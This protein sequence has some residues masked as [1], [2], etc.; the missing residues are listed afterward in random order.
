MTTLVQTAPIT[1]K[2]L[3]ILQINFERGWRGGER[4]TLLSMQAFRAAGHDV[5]LLARAGGDLA[6]RAQDSGFTVYPCSGIPAVGGTLL[7][8]GR[9]FD[10]LHAQTANMMTWLALLKPFCVHE[11]CLHGAPLFP[12]AQAVISKLAGNGDKPM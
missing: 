5:A 2:R 7:R 1:G 6:S 4:Q 12:L 8:Y 9:Q 3:R 11:W 10:I